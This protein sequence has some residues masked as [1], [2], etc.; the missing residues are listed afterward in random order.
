MSQSE[1]P[2]MLML[3][4]FKQIGIDNPQF[5]HTRQGAV[6]II[7]AL[8]ASSSDLSIKAGSIKM[9]APRYT[10]TELFFE[11]V[12]LNDL[13]ITRADGTRYQAKSLRVDNARFRDPE[14]DERGVTF[15]TI[16]ANGLSLEMAQTQLLFIPNLKLNATDWGAH[17]PIP[18]QL[19]FSGSLS[20]NSLVAGMLGEE[21]SKSDQPIQFASAGRY[22]MDIQAQ[23]MRSQ[24]V[25]KTNFGSSSRLDLTL[26]HL[27]LSVLSPLD[28]LL[29]NPDTSSDDLRALLFEQVLDAWKNVSASV[30]VDG[31][32]TLITSLLG[33]IFTPENVKATSVGE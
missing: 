24:L 14:A 4:F 23:K 13:E 12:E 18:A 11:A 6:E 9:Q 2:S 17:I 28:A 19:S 20:L 3:L 15:D 31:D 8:D 7:N 5:A 33:L 26:D 29:R 25:L 32:E 16:E 30:K 22:L 1:L 21:L 10:E 27:G